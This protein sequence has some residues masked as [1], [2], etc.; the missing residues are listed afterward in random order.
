MVREKKWLK[1]TGLL[2]I[3]LVTGLVACS[4]NEPGTSGNSGNTGNG[5]SN[6][7]DT[8]EKVNL[9]FMGQFG[10][11]NLSETDKL[12]M[13]SIGEATGTNITFDIPPSTGYAERLQLMLTTGEYPDLVYFSSPTDS[14]FLKAVKEG[15]I[16]PVDDYLGTADNLMKYSYDVSW[17]ALRVN[18]DGKIYGLP[19]TSVIRSDGYWVRQ[20]WLDQL[21]IELPE[22]NEI[23]L[24][25]M[26]EILTKFSKEDPDNN[27]RQDTYGFGANAGGDKSIS[28]LFTNVFGDLG[29]QESD[30]GEYKY[31]TPKFDLNNDAYSNS[32]EYTAKLFTEGLIDPDAPLIDSST[33]LERFTNG[34]TGVLRGFAGH[35][36]SVLRNGKK[37]NPD[38]ELAYVFVKNNDG[39]FQGLGQG[40]GLYGFWAV[41]S[42]AENPQKIIDVFDYMLSDEGWDQIYHGVVGHDYT[43]E[44]GT[45]VYAEESPE[46]FVRK[47]LVRRSEDYMFFINPDMPQE[48]QDQIVPNIQ[49]AV[50]NMVLSKDRDFTPAVAL[51]PPYLD[52]VKKIKETETKI[53]VGDLPVDAYT[54]VLEEWTER[55]GKEYLQ[56]MNDYIESMENP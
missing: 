55:F 16:V 22:N 5:N 48:L 20:D 28:P 36:E 10:S 37:I 25:E 34:T 13:Q 42:N 8:E 4:S 46:T 19:R 54:S 23:T 33:S 6:P 56:E 3:I 17:D 52:F 30:G 27:G 50:E 51:T 11:S 1:S 49:K 2:S 35:Y 44:N 40:T 31:M 21:N 15:V 12:L 47:N 45:R 43:V 38:F 7:P 18:R 39:Q 14:A 9:T 41:T 53:I 29:W 24:D 32:L 26:Y